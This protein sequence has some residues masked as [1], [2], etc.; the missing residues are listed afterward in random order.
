MNKTIEYLIIFA[1]GILL[2]ALGTQNYFKTK[3]EEITNEEI[4]SVKKAFGSESNKPSSNLPKKETAKEDTGDHY[5]SSV[6][7]A[8]VNIYR[9]EESKDDEVDYH[10]YY[11]APE[12]TERGDNMTRVMMATEEM[13]EREFPREEYVPELITQEEY[14]TTEPGFDKM[15]CTLYVPNM[16]VV[17][18]TSREVVENDI[19]G[20]DN[21]RYLADS[22]QT[23]GYIRNESISCDM[24]IAVLQ[25]SIEDTD[26]VV[27]FN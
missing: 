4:E 12:D 1:S 24:E 18:D 7:P 6:P 10:K 13:A 27:Y 5:L 25:D 11:D 19:L 9:S 21:I 2:G 17:D 3:Y 15:S 8:V 16:V 14:D 23:M 20:E 26:A 22:G